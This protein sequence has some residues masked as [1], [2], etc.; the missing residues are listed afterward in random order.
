[1][2]MKQILN[3]QTSLIVELEKFDLFSKISQ[4]AID[5]T[6]KLCYNEHIRNKTTVQRK[7]LKYERHSEFK[8]HLGCGIQ[9]SYCHSHPWRGLLSI[10]ST[11]P[12]Q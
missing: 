4:I 5:K 11:I 1:M 12:I 3:L 7:E 8:I 2:T 10:L 6:T 9:L